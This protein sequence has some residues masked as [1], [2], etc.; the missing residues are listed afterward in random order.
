VASNGIGC[1]DTREIAVTFGSLFAGIGGFDLGFE[2]AGMT[3][4]WQV[5]IDPYCQKVLEKH[6]PNV[7]RHDDVRTFPPTDPDEWRV[8][9]ICGGFPCQDISVAG[10]KLG[11]EG[12]R[13]GLFYEFMRIVGVV[14]PRVVVLEN[15]A[16]LLVRGMDAVLAELDALGFDAEWSVISACALGAPHPRERV[17]IIA[18]S[19]QERW[20]WSG[21]DS[22]G[23]DG[24]LHGR[25]NG[26]AT[27]PSA[28]WRD[29][30]RWLV[31]TFQN[32]DWESPQTALQRVDD[33]VPAWLDRN[34]MCGNAVV[35][36]VAEW[37]GHR[38]MESA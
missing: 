32:G 16:A 27:P 17:F 15:V 38:L 5:E 20:D 30:E 23:C 11:L 22:D 33:G 18:H 37:I 8:D 9:V 7:R 4:K 13:S 2:R 3:C 25:W 24:V 1:S 28:E 26:K 10:R 35:P 31:E 29:V 34:G 19:H 12:E 21:R 36:Q 6:W 14:R